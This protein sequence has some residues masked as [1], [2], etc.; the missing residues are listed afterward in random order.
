MKLKFDVPTI[1]FDFTEEQLK[2]F[3]KNY[4]DRVPELTV[5]EGDKFSDEFIEVIR[6]IKL[7]EILE[8]IRLI[9]N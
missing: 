2:K 7:S 5:L 1:E 9:S 4:E 6:M 3:V 8:D